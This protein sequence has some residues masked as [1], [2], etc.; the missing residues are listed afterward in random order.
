[1]ARE[2]EEEVDINSEIAI[3]KKKKSC[4]NKNIRFLY[5]IKDK[6]DKFW[7]YIYKEFNF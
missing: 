2:E 6:Y 5:N 1:M 7:W 3:S 4:N